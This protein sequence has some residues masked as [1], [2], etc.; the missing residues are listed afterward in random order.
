[1]LG[2]R[3][4]GAVATTNRTAKWKDVEILA[5]IQNRS[6]EYD[7]IENQVLSDPWAEGYHVRQAG[8]T[9]LS[10]P[11]EPTNI[12]A[13]VRRERYDLKLKGWAECDKEMRERKGEK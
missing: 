11:V 3:P 1:M 8:G 9:M 12:L 2:R 6:G 13:A 4:R 10:L 5:Y 7:E